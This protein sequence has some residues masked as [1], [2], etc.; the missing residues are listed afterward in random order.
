MHKSQ[1]V[2]FRFG[3]AAV[4][5]ALAVGAGTAWRAEAAFI[6]YICNDSSCVGGG[7]VIVTDDAGSDLFPTLAGI[8]GAVGS[9]G[10]L[11]IE[12]NTSQSKPLIGSAASPEMDLSFL[13]TGVGEA[14]F[15]ASDTDFT[16]VTSFLLQL[17][18][19]SSAA[20]FTLTANA[21]GG[22]DN[23]NL[24]LAPVLAI[25]GPLSTSPFSG[26]ATTGVV[27][28]VVNPYSLTLGLHIKQNSFGTT[29]GD[30]NLSVAEPTSILL[31]GLGL[32][33]AG[34]LSTRRARRRR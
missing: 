18:G 17:G 32:V 34:M 25:I 21:F 26:S 22:S 27:G 20:P 28:S 7:D 9:V 23:L 4:A 2:M 13:A 3:V 14:W 1:G 31:L 10:G 16:G 6:A 19:T 12:L 5:V 30:L 24:S 33:G 8:I 11:T 29:T 15:Y